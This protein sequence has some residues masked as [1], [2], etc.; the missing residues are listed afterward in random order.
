MKKKKKVLDLTVREALLLVWQKK[1]VLL[2]TILILLF[3]SLSLF[4]STFREHFLFDRYDKFQWIGVS[5]IFAG[6][7]LYFSSILK[8][9]EIRANVLTKNDLDLLKDF[10]E[11]IS[12]FSA[13]VW[14]YNN[15]LNEVLQFS[16]QNNFFEINF[17]AEFDKKEKK[18]NRKYYNL[19]GNELNDMYFQIME[20][21]TKIYFDLTISFDDSAVNVNESLTEIKQLLDNTIKMNEKTQKFDDIQFQYLEI[22]RAN[23]NLIVAARSYIVL[24]M[25]NKVSSFNSKIIDNNKK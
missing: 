24:V 22:I 2:I 13:L 7:G 21:Y 14:K 4:S 3:I 17:N 1:V 20:L 5:A 23:N 10:R 12:N 9:E 25:E 11:N 6:V 19:K 16:R 18:Q 8:K 15:V